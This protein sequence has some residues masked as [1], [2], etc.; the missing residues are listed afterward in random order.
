MIEKIKFKK[1]SEKEMF[2][3]CC[4]GEALC[5]VQ[6]I[7]DALSHS[8][9]I[10][11]TEPSQKK[12]ADNL[13]KKQRFYT[14]GRAI[15]IAKKEALIPESLMIELS[16]LLKERNWLIHESLI[17]NKDEFLSDSF[18][19]KLSKKT[20]DISLKANKLQIKIE[21]DLIEYTEKK[22]IDLSEIKS[23]MNKHYGI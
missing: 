23:K 7:E 17:E 18:F 9:I 12:E 5:A 2:L 16:D 3:Y 19:K 14:F 22:G 13:L 8:I 4:L 11:K 15:N 10:K 6:I 21:L 20:K 1:A